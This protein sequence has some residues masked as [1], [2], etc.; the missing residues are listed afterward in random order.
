[1]IL[2]KNKRFDFRNWSSKIA[3]IVLHVQR[4][5]MRA[6]IPFNHSHSFGSNDIFSSL[7]WNVIK[8]WEF[9]KGPFQKFRLILIVVGL[10]NKIYAL[11]ELLIPFVVWF[12]LGSTWFKISC[13]TWCH[14]FCIW[15]GVS[16][17]SFVQAQHTTTTAGFRIVWIND[18]T[19]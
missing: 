14:T 12:G 4:S 5:K 6:K 11:N 10:K 18:A 16:V 13:W 7:R 17:G 3:A 15:K 9:E 8:V 2:N 1:M 19:P